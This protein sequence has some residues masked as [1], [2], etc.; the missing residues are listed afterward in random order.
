MR[1]SHFRRAAERLEN[2][3]L[4]GRPLL[5]RNGRNRSRRDDASDSRHRLS[6]AVGRRN[7]FVNASRGLAVEG[8]SGP[9]SGR[10]PR[11]VRAA[12]AR[13]QS[14]A[15]FIQR[16]FTVYF[17][18]RQSA[19]F[20]FA[21]EDVAVSWQ[22][23]A[24]RHNPLDLGLVGLV[25]FLPQLLLALPAGV[26]ADRFER[27]SICVLSSLAEAIGLLGFIALHRAARPCAWSLSGS[28]RVH[29]R[30]PHR[31]HSRAAFAARDHRPARSV[32]ARTGP[33]VVGDAAHRDSRPGSRRRLDCARAR[34][35]RSS[36]LRPRT[37]LPRSHLR[38][39]GRAKLRTPTS[40]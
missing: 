33:L 27:R 23:F 10:E 40:R 2:P 32:R 35:S 24:L 22:V 4:D 20:A 38:F 13:Q 36:R 34:R 3:A 1:S 8:R 12:L 17:I 15:A 25:L 5:A 9:R 28:G 7:P 29:R 18:A 6:G 14:L 19:M 16:E 26:L 21:V 39:C 31:R 30:S 37:A 11:V